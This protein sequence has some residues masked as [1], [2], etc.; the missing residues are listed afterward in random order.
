MNKD[1]FKDRIYSLISAVTFDYKGK[2]CG[3]DP[4]SHQQYDVWY[5]DKCKTMTDINQVMNEPFFDN[6]SLADIVPYI[7]NVD[8]E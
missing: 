7:K 6:Q 4:L 5:G 2:R 1:V 3:V 8:V